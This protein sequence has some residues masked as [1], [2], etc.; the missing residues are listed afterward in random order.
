MGI[1]IHLRRQ[2]RRLQT[3]SMLLRDLWCFGFLYRISCECSGDEQ[4][5][6]GICRSGQLEK[7][8]AF[9]QYHPWGRRPRARPWVVWFTVATTFAVR[10][11][12]YLIT[13][14]DK[15]LGRGKKK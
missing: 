9:A 6:T 2:L 1:G 7:V 10:A 15:F 3:Q 11:Q 14:A 8:T 12:A 13:S 5:R 4:C